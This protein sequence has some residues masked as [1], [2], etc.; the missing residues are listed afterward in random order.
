[1]RQKTVVWRKRT[2]RHLFQK[3]RFLKDFSDS[4]AAIFGYSGRQGRWL[5]S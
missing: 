3:R 5:A 2:S 1:M 4:P